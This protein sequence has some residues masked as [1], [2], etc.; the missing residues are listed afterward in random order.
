VAGVGLLTAGPWNLMLGRR[1]IR[2]RLLW[3]P[4][5]L[6]CPVMGAFAIIKASG[7]LPL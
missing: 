3:I 2:I 7:V 1:D 5:W 6:F 4:A